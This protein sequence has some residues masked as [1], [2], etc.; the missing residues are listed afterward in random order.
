[1]SEPKSIDEI[2]AGLSAL[3]PASAIEW[4]PQSITKDKSRA[5]AVP[6]VDARDIAERLDH[7]VGAFG[8]QRVHNGAS[9]GIGIKHPETGEWIWK[10]D[11][12]FVTGE[13]SDKEDAQIKGIKGTAS[14]SF[15]RAAY[16]WGIARYLYKFPKQWVAWDEEKRDFKT[17]P[18]IPEWALLANEKQNS[19]SKQNTAQ[20]TAQNAER[21][22]SVQRANL[23][24][25]YE[26]LYL[27]N[28]ADAVKGLGEMFAKEF[29]HSG[30]DATFEEAKRLEAKL[31]A[32]LNAKKKSPNARPSA[33]A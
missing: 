17:K 3:F 19:A 24:A 16:M 32:E 8:W 7:V 5:L 2:V 26:K 20:N 12:G 1:M 33:R 22:T 25:L 13:D 21:M 11:V 6:F 18:Q 28:G 9:V 31:T 15:K 23:I 30:K 29:K 4:K 10:Y 27:V 14:D